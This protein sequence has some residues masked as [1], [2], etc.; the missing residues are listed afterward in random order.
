MEPGKARDCCSAAAMP[1]GCRQ[2][3]SSERSL[4][5]PAWV[6]FRP[7]LGPEGEAARKLLQ[8]AMRVLGAEGMA[9]NRYG[10]LHPDGYWGEG[11]QPFCSDKLPPPFFDA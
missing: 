8:H 5:N 2:A 3:I 6:G 4:S 10:A 1:M 7:K 11:R 9:I